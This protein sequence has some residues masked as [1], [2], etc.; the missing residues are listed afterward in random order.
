MT[1]VLFLLTTAEPTSTT[2]ASTSIATTPAATTTTTTEASHLS[3]ARINLL[4][5]LLE[6]VDKV[7]RLL[8]V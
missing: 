5:G 4:L 6:D 2:A 1:S 7:T 3:K 8:L